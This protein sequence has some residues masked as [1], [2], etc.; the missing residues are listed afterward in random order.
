LPAGDKEA[1]FERLF[2]A[3]HD[4]ILAYALRRTDSGDAEDVVADTFAVAW[5]R[6][7]AIPPDPL[8]WLYGVARRTLANSRRS[9]RRRAQLASRLAAD[10]GPSLRTGS[11]PAEQLG[12]VAVMQAALG[13]LKERDREALM[14]VAWEGLDN[15]RA[16]LALG[17]SPETFAVRL[18]R[19]R[20]RLQAEVDRLA[21]AEPLGDRYPPEER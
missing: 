6:F 20:R 16:A 12:D 2:R 4:R 17:V 1:A 7:E 19:A 14:L 21:E 5:R 3:N 18:H 10:L 13:A 9:L 15:Q 11:D 8:P